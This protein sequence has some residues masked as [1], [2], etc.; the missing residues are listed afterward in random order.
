MAEILNTKVKRNVLTP[1]TRVGLL[2][3]LLSGGIILSSLPEGYRVHS[4]PS[5]GF[6]LGAGLIMI[7]LTAV[8]FLYLS[9]LRLGFKS[10]ALTLALGYNAV[11]A[12]IKFVLSPYAM[13][14]QGTINVQWFDP[15]SPE[16]YILTAG[17]ILLLYVLVFNIVYKLSKRRV[18]KALSQPHVRSHR[19]RNSLAVLIPVVI[20]TCV[21][22]GGVALL[23]GL[24]FVGTPLQYLGFLWGTVGIPL[25]AA[26]VLAVWL[27]VKAFQ[28]VEAQAIATRSATL[29]ASFFWLGLSLILLYHIMWIVF[30]ITLVHVWPFNTYTPK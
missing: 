4:A 15:N 18:E 26:I 8:L 5:F 23:F 30:M 29:L 3:F 1:S 16:Y 27:A 17:V 7:A 28:V 14:Q 19:V 22:T 20:I 2:L 11:I 9:R 6:F 25:V 10:T 13:Y 12:V 21:A 24:L